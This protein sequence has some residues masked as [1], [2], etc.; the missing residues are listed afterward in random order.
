MIIHVFKRRIFIYKHRHFLPQLNL[1]S[2]DNL[3]RYV[4]VLDF[5]QINVLFLKDLILKAFS[6]MNILKIKK[7]LLRTTYEC[8]P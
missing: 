6:L 7:L 2:L 1:D 4:N 8:L 3:H 5:V